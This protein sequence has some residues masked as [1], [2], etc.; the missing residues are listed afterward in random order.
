M[1]VGDKIRRKYSFKTQF[2]PSVHEWNVIRQKRTR[3]S[4]I[5]VLT[6]NMECFRRIFPLVHGKKKEGKTTDLIVGLPTSSPSMG[7]GTPL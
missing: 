2:D 7:L 5:S 4:S 6:I 1:V 3:N